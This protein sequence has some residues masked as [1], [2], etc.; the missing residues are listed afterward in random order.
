MISSIPKWVSNLFGSTMRPNVKVLE[1]HYISPHIKKIHFQGDISKWNFQIGYASV[2]RVSETEF[3]NYTVAYHDKAKGF[4]NII[5]HVHGNEVG[6]LFI[7]NL[8]TGDELFISPPRGKKFYET[9]NTKQQFIFGDETSLGLACSF[10]PILKQN[11]HQ[12]QFYFELDDRNKD[13]PQ[14]LA[15]EN[16]TVFPKNG[17]FRNEKW[18]NDLPISQAVDWQAGS[19]I[20]TGNAKSV[21][22]FRKVLKSITTRNIFFQGYWLEGKKGL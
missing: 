11:Q 17:Y 18:I 19:F 2:I 20:L 4:F 22:T 15:L 9:D 21:Q 1:T 14:L 16:V 13:I 10:L 5:F 8:K 3:R 12:F 6:S 7:D